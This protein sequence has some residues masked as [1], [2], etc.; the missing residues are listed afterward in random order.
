MQV[1]LKVRWKWSLSCLYCRDFQ[2]EWNSVKLIIF[3]YTPLY[4]QSSQRATLYIAVWWQ[5]KDAVLHVNSTMLL[6][7]CRYRRVNDTHTMDIRSQWADLIFESHRFWNHPPSI[8]DRRA[9]YVSTPQPPCHQKSNVFGPDLWRPA[10]LFQPPLQ[11]IVYV[12]PEDTN[13][14]RTRASFAW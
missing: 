3:N 14:M 4:T 6:L 1:Q 5:A 8:L 2:W 10:L 13:L 7:C 9:H 12:P 11:N